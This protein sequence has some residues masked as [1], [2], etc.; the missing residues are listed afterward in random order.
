[1]ELIDTHCHLDLDDY[2]RDRPEVMERARSAGISHLITIGLNPESS[3]RAIALAE[4]HDFISAT[5]GYHPHEA[6][7]LTDSDLD[8]LRRL[9]RHPRVVG[10]GEIGLD[11]Y[12]NRSPRPVQRRRFDDLIRIGVELGLPLI[13][14]DR[15]AHQETLEH[16]NSIK[17]DLQG[18]VIHCFSGD[19]DLARRFLD[20]GFH[21]SIPGTITFPKAEV[22]REVTAR[23]PLERLLLETDAPFLAPVPRR[24]RRNEPALMAYTAAEAARL[25]NI[26]LADLARATTGNAR[27]LF[28][29]PKANPAENESRSCPRPR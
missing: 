2:D 1:M 17:A 12:R 28:K 20:M 8:R 7:G 13:I 6:A 14:H 24:G 4:S 21:L 29:L 25:R 5:V 23:M 3:A 26:P 10:F 19:Y 9:G 15:D 22:I 11:F 18:G 16:L 27:C